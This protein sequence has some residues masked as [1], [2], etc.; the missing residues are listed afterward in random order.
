[1]Y[2]I[3]IELQDPRTWNDGRHGNRVI[4][5]HHIVAMAMHRGSK[6]FR[7][8][9]RMPMLGD[10]GR[11]FLHGLQQVG[12]MEWHRHDG[13]QRNTEADHSGATA[14]HEPFK[15][16]VWPSHHS[17]IGGASGGLGK[18]LAVSSPGG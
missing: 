4:M 2:Q 10:E 17:I 6:V 14:S 13:P 18:R 11:V 16:Y 15:S 5:F 1:M 8:S 12:D 3:A 9:V 7:K